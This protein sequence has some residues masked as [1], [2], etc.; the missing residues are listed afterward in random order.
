MSTNYRDEAQRELFLDESQQSYLAMPASAWQIV[1]AGPGSGKTTA[2]IQKVIALDSEFAGSEE[3]VEPFAVLFLSFSTASIQ[4]ASRSMNADIAQLEVEFQA[5][6]IDSLAYEICRYDG[7]MSLE[8]LERTGFEDR[9]FR[10]KRITEEQ[11][12]D[13]TYDLVHVFVD[14]AQD[15]TPSQAEFL[16]KYLSKLPGNC[17]VTVFA[18]PD[19]EIYRFLDSRSSSAPRWDSFKDKLLEIHDW[20]H[21]VFTGQYR[22]QTPIMQRLFCELARVRDESDRDSK[23]KILDRTQARLPTTTPER[24]ARSAASKSSTAALL[25]RTNAEV[26]V[27]FDHLARCGHTNLRPVLPAEWRELYPRWIGEAANLMRRGTFSSNELTESIA[28][29]DVDPAS[30]EHLNLKL[31]REMTWQEVRQA[32]NGLRAPKSAGV[33]GEL[34]LS[35]IHQSKGLEFEE[36]GILHPDQLLIRNPVEAE[37][38]FVALSR[39]KRTAY[40]V[41]LPDQETNFQSVGRHS[42]SYAYQGKRK[43]LTHISILP[44]DITVPEALGRVL[45]SSNETLDEGSFISFEPI[46]SRNRFCYV[47]KVDEVV[48]G[49]TTE[50][51]GQL[52]KSKS[53]VGKPPVLGSVPIAHI[54]TRFVPSADGSRPI[55][56]PVPFGISEILP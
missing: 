7:Q 11:G 19:Q 35:T 26:V 14:E 36:V 25:A 54:E 45:A 51:F 24:L 17:G 44:S 31:S 48:V 23:R 56:V 18:D 50:Q 4:A 47:C 13:L 28:L 29:L 49:E 10:A 33:P 5:Q 34:T 16:T 27:C 6:T 9:L 2:A 22:A 15:V 37:L 21:I 32:Y 38:L 3:T 43:C 40:S 20:H 1:T 30:I 8:E 12:T 55:L 46:D 52:L 39:A 41:N 42:V 53:G